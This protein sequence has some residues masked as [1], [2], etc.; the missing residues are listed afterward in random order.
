MKKLGVEH[1]NLD[2]KVYKQVKSMI[3]GQELLPGTKIYQDRLANDL[4][5]SR[6][7]LVAALKK[8]EQERLIAAIPRRGFYV[9]RFSQEEMIH[10]F[11]LR[12]VLEG[13][14]ARRSA[15]YITD[16]QV[17]KLKSFFK[18]LK[19][20]DHSKDL[21]KYAEED[22]RFHHFLMEVG[23]ND[24]LS[25]ILG[26]YSIITYSYLGSF[27]E[28]LVRS[29]KETIDEHVALIQ[30]ISNRNPAKA[31]ELARL[32]LKLSRDRLKQ[33]NE[34]EGQSARKD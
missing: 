14:A 32:H 6:T 5:I 7:P 20:S 31:E 34:V 24:L 29:P 4:A 25:S 30:A 22:R 3:L 23:G 33:E 8:L 16:T 2:H 10:I 28:G 21:R 11:E 9:R 19:I 17:E 15:L 18:G 13:L 27:Q 12:E 1:E 26:T